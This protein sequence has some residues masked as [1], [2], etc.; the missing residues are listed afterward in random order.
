MDFSDDVVVNVVYQGIKRGIQV[1][2]GNECYDSCVKLI[3]CGIDAMAYLSLPS[4]RDEVQG[5]DFI[6][7]ADKYLSP[8][9]SD[10]TRLVTGTEL[11]SARCGLVH[12]HCA[13]SDLTKKRGVRVVLYS[14]GRGRHILWSK[15]SK[16]P[17]ILL[18]MEVLRDAFFDAMNEFLPQVFSDVAMQPVLEARLRKLAVVLPYSKL[19]QAVREGHF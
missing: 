12:T 2:W 19:E 13:E 14:Y 17:S 4:E 1:T 5:K 15:E 11:Y 3:Y 16:P 18:P 8:K 10:G 6:D 9:L 7:W